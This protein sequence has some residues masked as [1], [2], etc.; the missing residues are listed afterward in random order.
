MWVSSGGL[1]R[2][3]PSFSETFIEARPRAGTEGAG[4]A[5]EFPFPVGGAFIEAR[6]TSD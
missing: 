6:M 4:G 5:K 2:N 3:F 1:I